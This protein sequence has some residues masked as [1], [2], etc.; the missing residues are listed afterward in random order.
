MGLIL[1]IAPLLQFVQADQVFFIL[2]SRANLREIFRHRQ[3]SPLR[4]AKRTLV[5]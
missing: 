4:R 3:V 2:Q 1:S 5:V